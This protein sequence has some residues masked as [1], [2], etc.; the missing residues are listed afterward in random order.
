MRSFI[1]LNMIALKFAD[2]QYKEINMEIKISYY[3]IAGQLLS[4]TK[5]YCKIA[6]SIETVATQ[7][8]FLMTNAI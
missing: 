4:S 5:K 3:N 2:T 1:Q 7:D 6:I 8:T